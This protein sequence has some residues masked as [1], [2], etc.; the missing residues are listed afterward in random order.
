MILGTYLTLVFVLS[1]ATF[2]AYGW[3]KRRAERGVRRI[4]ERTL[5]L[6]AACGGWPGGLLGQRH[7]RHKTQKLWFL[8]M[9][10]CLTLLHFAIVATI[11]YAMYGPG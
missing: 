1:L 9:F 6:L 11:A 10:W 7:F 3:D 5:H 2:L 8:I 4:P